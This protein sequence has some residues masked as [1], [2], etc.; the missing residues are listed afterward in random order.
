MTTKQKMEIHPWLAEAK[1][2]LFIYGCST[3]SGSYNLCWFHF[4]HVDHSPVCLIVTLKSSF[5]IRLWLLNAYYEELLAWIGPYIMPHILTD[6]VFSMI[7]IL[8]QENFQA[9]Y[10]T[11]GNSTRIMKTFRDTCRLAP[12]ASLLVKTETGKQHPA[13]CLGSESSQPFYGNNQVLFFKKRLE[14]PD[15]RDIYILDTLLNL[16]ND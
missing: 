15:I 2:E 5:L 6:K 4:F 3:I 1:R 11:S 9:V 10:I 16:H 13:P 7:Q 8:C 12:G 14:I